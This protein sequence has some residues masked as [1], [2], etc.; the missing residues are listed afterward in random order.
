MQK[1]DYTKFHAMLQQALDGRSQRAFAQEC[2]MLPQALNRLM[3][4]ESGVPSTETLR[5]IAMH[6]SIPLVDLLTVCGYPETACRDEPA[7]V[8]TPVSAN[9]EKDFL[10]LAR[11]IVI[12]AATEDKLLKA[13]D[14]ADELIDSIIVT[15]KT[16]GRFYHMDCHRA[17]HNKETGR[18]LLEFKGMMPLKRIRCYAV[19]SVGATGKLD[20]DKTPLYYL[21]DADFK[22]GTIEK[23]FPGV[24][25]RD[26]F[27]DSE[28][29]VN[30]DAAYA[31]S[32][33]SDLAIAKHVSK[34]TMLDEIF[35]KRVQVPQLCEGI[36]F[37]VDRVDE[38]TLTDFVMAHLD[39][40]PDGTIVTEDDIQY[41]RNPSDEFETGLFGAVLAIIRSMTG[42]RHVFYYPVDPAVKFHMNR[43]VIMVP[44][45]MIGDG[46]GLYHE[47]GV[48]E[49]M[50]RTAYMLDVVHYGKV[51]C[52]D[53][54]D[55]PAEPECS[56]YDHMPSADASKLEE[57][58]Q[59]FAEAGKEEKAET[60]SESADKTDAEE[61]SKTEAEAKPEEAGK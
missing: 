37:Y 34:T 24:L 47:A 45:Y 22:T 58:K 10:T 43:P 48:Y 36:G 27:D 51:W 19:V 39:Y 9:T 38:P 16:E 52:I 21:L 3:K 12:E 33:P 15:A 53:I 13:F 32:T 8:K 57:A 46:A 1:V 17:G 23:E 26:I 61:D 30:L 18:T 41:Y 20:G 35:R 59:D 25:P 50:R 28:H 4:Q 60:E 7:R 54:T 49:A 29:P 55:V 6:S 42:I 2:G 11:K 56:I 14:S 40:I 31:E 44:R 5:K